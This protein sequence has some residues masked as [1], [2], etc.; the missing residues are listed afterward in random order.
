MKQLNSLIMRVFLPPDEPDGFADPVA[1]AGIIIN[2]VL[3][4]FVWN[5][6]Y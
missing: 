4:F 5:L 6:R 3:S 1:K 2:G